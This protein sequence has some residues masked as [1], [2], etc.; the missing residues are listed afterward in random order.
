MQDN[1]RRRGTCKVGVAKFKDFPIRFKTF[2]FTD[3][4]S[5]NSP[6]KHKNFR[7]LDD[8]EQNLGPWPPFRCPATTSLGTTSDVLI[9]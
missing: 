6:V 5:E 3:S 4:K 2:V 8:F 9:D 1:Q 7:K